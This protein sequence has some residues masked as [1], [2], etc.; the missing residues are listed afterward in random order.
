MIYGL[1]AALGWGLADVMVA[2]IARRI[3]SFVTLV[4]GQLASLIAFTMLWLSGVTSVG[5]LHPALLLLP[6]IGVS[7]ALSYV[8]FYRALELGPIALV[9]PIA[10]GYAAIVIALALLILREPV[11]PLAV[12]GAF[13][14]IGGVVLA[15][16]DLHDIGVPR[17]GPRSG[18]FFAVLAMLGFGF[19]A[20]LIGHFAK[21]VGWFG[22]IYLSRAGSAI[23]LLVIFFGVRRG[24]RRSTKSDPSSWLTGRMKLPRHLGA[25]APAV[26]I[27]LLDIM[28]FASFARGAELGFISITA[29]ASVTYPLIPIVGGVLYLR[30]RPAA[31]QWLGVAVV[32]GGL[33]LLAVGR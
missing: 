22:A 12:V 21:D 19:G 3:G 30:E 33:I 5:H 17:D 2:L 28:G 9:S 14:A 32:V 27:G 26:V 16:T 25:M 18:V 31:S 7:G 15:S 24:A 4:I 10:A 20:F 11:P 23:T 13:V 6:L 1:G 8:C 29:A